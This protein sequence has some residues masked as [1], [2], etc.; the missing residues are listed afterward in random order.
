MIWIV[1]RT[2]RRRRSISPSGS[3]E[4]NALLALGALALRRDDLDGAKNYLETARDI[5]GQIGSKLGKAHTLKSLCNLALQLFDLD[6]AKE[7][8]EMARDIYVEIGSR[9]G[10]ANSLV[11]LG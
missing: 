5:S 3:G 8:L 10:E 1:Q 9:L 2:I 4:A 6:A 11:S 7:Y